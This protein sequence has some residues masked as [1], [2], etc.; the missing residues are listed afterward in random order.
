M[1]DRQDIA[2]LNRLAE[3]DIVE[4]DSPSAPTVSQKPVDEHPLSDSKRVDAAGEDAPP[5]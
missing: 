3:P 4:V 2:E 5:L 1:T